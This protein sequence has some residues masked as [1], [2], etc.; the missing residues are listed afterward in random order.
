MHRANVRPEVPQQNLLHE[1]ARVALEIKMGEAYRTHKDEYNQSF[2]YCRV[3]TER[4][5]VSADLWG[6]IE[7]YTLRGRP[8]RRKRELRSLLSATL[9]AT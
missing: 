4:K 1:A 6:V 7:D 9:G 8:S 2:D 5:E 3:H